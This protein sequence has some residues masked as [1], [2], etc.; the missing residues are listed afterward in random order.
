MNRPL[1]AVL[2]L[3]LPIAL[4]LSSAFAQSDIDE[5]AIQ[6][7]T[8]RFAAAWNAHDAATMAAAY[9]ADG[10]L[11]DPFQSSR[12]RPAVEA[13][14]AGLIAGPGAQSTVTAFDVTDVELLG[15]GLA[16]ADAVQTVEGMIAPDGTALPPQTFTVTMVLRF[17]GGS[18]GYRAVRVSF[19]PPPQP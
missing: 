1:G 4:T 14:F 16:L 6:A 8:D 2:A 10:S 7:L 17:E 15:D 9:T 3:A 12:G 18:W 5:A 19:S 11:T 13:A